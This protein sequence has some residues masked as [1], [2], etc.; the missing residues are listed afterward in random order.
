[1]NDKKRIN[2]VLLKQRCLYYLGNYIILFKVIYQQKSSW[3]KNSFCRRPHFQ[4]ITN[5]SF[6]VNNYLTD[7]TVASFIYCCYHT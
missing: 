2:Q 5:L 1:M 6:F 4:Y 3:S 7:A